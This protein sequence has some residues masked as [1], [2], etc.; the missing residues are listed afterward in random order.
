MIDKRKFNK[1]LN[2]CANP[3]EQELTRA[4]HTLTSAMSKYRNNKH[5]DLAHCQSTRQNHRASK[6]AY[7]PP[8]NVHNKVISKLESINCKTLVFLYKFCQ[9]F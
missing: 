6:S 3:S 2:P 4:L 9:Q 8:G 1:I 7:S 5:Y